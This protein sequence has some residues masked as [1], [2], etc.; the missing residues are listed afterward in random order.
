MNPEQAGALRRRLPPGRDGLADFL[1]LPC[2][3]LP[4][5]SPDPA[6]QPGL[7]QARAGSFPDHGA[8][9]L[10]EGPGLP[11]ENWTVIE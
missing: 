9:E 8:L 4:L 3:Q 5:P 1:F 11:P 7:F 10:G 6:F 2:G